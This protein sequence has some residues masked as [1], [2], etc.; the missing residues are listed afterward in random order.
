M[1]QLQII[2]QS[3]ARVLTTQQLAE[4]Y[5]T[6][7]TR[8][9]QNFN[10]NTKRYTEGKHF[11]YLVGENL[12]RFKNEVGNSDLV[13]KNASSLYLWSEKGAWL[14]AKS[15]NT[16]EA[17]EAYEMLVDDYY[18]IKIQ[19]NVTP[20]SKESFEMQ[21]IGVEY[22]SKILR[23]DETSKI[24]MLEAAHKQHSV[25]TNHL[26]AYVDEEVTKSLTALLKEFDL[27]FGAAKA[28]TRLIELGI[29]EIK[30]RQSSK[31]GMKE[32][33]S[34]TEK[35]LEFGKNLINPK[36]PKE[37]QPH[38]YPGEFLNLIKLMESEA[39]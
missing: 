31:G 3:G 9:K 18:R 23:V 21:L 24:R 7:S 16:D 6:D 26:P 29:L 22:T 10:E 12:K 32:F 13:G 20:A 5:G 30:E 8:I 38:Y 4:S 28:N 36:S 2:E 15:L 37:T 1:N 17:W 35:G 33:K 14:H 19:E 25:P 34:L 39:A 27:K 11:L